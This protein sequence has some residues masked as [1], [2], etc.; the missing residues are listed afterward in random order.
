MFNPIELAMLKKLGGGG[1]SGGGSGSG[2]GGAFVVTFTYDENEN[3]IA[4]KTL[5][6]LAEAVMSGRQISGVVA[7]VDEEESS[8]YYLRL[9]SAT[10]SNEFIGF[11]FDGI[12]GWDGSGYTM[13]TVNYNSNSQ[14]IGEG[15]H[16]VNVTSVDM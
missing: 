2:G 13:H 11:W 15:Y 7:F 10:V 14:R 3:L 9:Y 8:F 5:D 16:K 6:E 1:G 4:D 12:E